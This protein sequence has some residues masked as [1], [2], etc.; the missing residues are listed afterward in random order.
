MKLIT[1]P[2][3]TK[4]SIWKQLDRLMNSLFKSIAKT[5]TWLLLWT[6]GHWPIGGFV[7]K[8]VF[9]S[10]FSCLTGNKFCVIIILF[11]TRSWNMTSLELTWAG[12]LFG[13]LRYKDTLNKLIEILPKRNSFQ[14]NKCHHDCTVLFSLYNSEI[15]LT[16][17]SSTFH[18]NGSLSRTQIKD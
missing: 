16:H 10:F 11:L 4:L 7:L 17:L 3:K 12:R 8:N 13:Q 15:M 1:P 6:I 14:R 18:P 5:K 2:M 9:F